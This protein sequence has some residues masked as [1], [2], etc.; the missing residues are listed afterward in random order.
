MA[1]RQITGGNFQDASG[2]TLNGGSV[3]FRLS[4]DA[5][6]TGTQV[7]AS[8]L[9]SA[10]LDASGN[11]SGTVSLWPNDQLD[12]TDTVYRITA[13]NSKGQ[14]VWNSENVIPSGV[15]PFDIGT[16]VPLY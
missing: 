6:A 9:T 3:I 10:V 2:N 4:T 5:V 15:G 12:P 7:V 8:I 13:Y 1:K 11:I 14:P 16:L